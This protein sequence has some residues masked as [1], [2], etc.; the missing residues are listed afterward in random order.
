MLKVPRAQDGAGVCVCGGWGVDTGTALP[1]TFLCKWPAGCVGEGQAV[2]RD[3]S[4]SHP[5][6][7]PAHHP[8][9]RTPG[10]Y[11]SQLLSGCMA[12]GWRL[13]SP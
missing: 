4:V 12:L 7:N 6:G 8:G 5:L 10:F 9:I 2:S 13:P 1:L 3:A 11:P